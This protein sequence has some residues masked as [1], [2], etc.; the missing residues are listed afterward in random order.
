MSENIDNLV[1]KMNPS[2]IEILLDIINNLQ[3]TINYTHDNLIKRDKENFEIS[4]D[5]EDE[6][7][8]SK[9]VSKLK[10]GEKRKPLELFNEKE[11]D[12]IV[13]ENTN[14]NRQNK[15]KEGIS[16][17]NNKEKTIKYHCFEIM[18]RIRNE[19]VKIKKIFNDNKKKIIN[20][21][22]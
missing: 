8:Y 21:M 11:N 10:I 14:K 19:I 17:R 5:E 1:N 16:F 2:N 18:K 20:V 7:T 4:L 3:E 13:N 22:V 9:K 6:L 15:I 12:N